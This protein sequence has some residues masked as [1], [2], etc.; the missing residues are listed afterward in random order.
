MAS[1]VRTRWFNRCRR[2]LLLLAAVWIINAFDLG[3]TL[4]ETV[5]GHFVEMNPIAARMLGGPVY[6]VVAYKA[7]LVGAGTV[8]LL[9]LRRHSV[10]ELTCWFLLAAHV[11]LAVRW[12]VYFELTL[13][14][15][16]R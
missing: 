7:G 15:A 9:W 5:R 3:F 12:Y 4:V 11:Y 8:I 16:G 2:M 10:A 1:A 6:A 14:A 13:E